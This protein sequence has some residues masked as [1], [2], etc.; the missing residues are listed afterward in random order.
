MSCFV[1]VSEFILNLCEALVKHM[2]HDRRAGINI[3][4]E[5]SGTHAQWVADTWNYLVY[6]AVCLD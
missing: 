1:M 4:W 5:M 2:I 3:G 6:V